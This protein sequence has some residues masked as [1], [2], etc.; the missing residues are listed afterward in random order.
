MAYGGGRNLIRDL[1]GKARPR[2]IAL[3]RGVERTDDAVLLAILLRTGGRRG[4]GVME[5]ARDVLGRCGHSLERLA[6]A[7]VEELV[8]L[9]GLG[10]VKALELKAALELGRR[11]ATPDTA[12]ARPVVLGPAPVVELLGAEAARL[13]REVFWV[14][15]LN[16]KYRLLRPPVEITSGLLD[17]SLA[18]PREVFREAVR[19]MAAAIVLAHNHPSGDPKPSREDVRMTRRLVDAGRVVGIPVLDHVIIGRGAFPPPYVGLRDAG[20]VQFDG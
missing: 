11:A 18:H 10:P 9:P 17:T 19:S 12:G 20:A 6:D 5:L 1:P 2:E 15:P 8:E 4:Q 7:S 14:L 13:D 16:A 3:E